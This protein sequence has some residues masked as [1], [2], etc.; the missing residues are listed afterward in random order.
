MH[1]RARSPVRICRLKSH[2]LAAELGK[3]TR[4]QTLLQEFFTEDAPFRQYVA[5]DGTE[6]VGWVRSVKVL[7]SRRRSHMQVVESHRRRGIGTRFWARCC[8]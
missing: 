4:V 5:L 8:G 3:A 1:S 2:K 7:Y 6:L